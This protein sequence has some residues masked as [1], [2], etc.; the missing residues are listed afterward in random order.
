MIQN[1]SHYKIRRVRRTFFLRMRF[2]WFVSESYCYPLSDPTEATKIEFAAFS[3]IFLK[4][5]EFFSVD[6]FLKIKISESKIIHYQNFNVYF[7]RNKFTK[8]IRIY[9]SEGFCVN[10][11]LNIASRSS[12]SQMFFKI[13]VLKILLSKST[14][15]FLYDGNIGR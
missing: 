1:C 15:W 5:I 2:I 14:D 8:L 4:I 12:R 13:G 10:M 7:S 9:G 3:I 6:I 11:W